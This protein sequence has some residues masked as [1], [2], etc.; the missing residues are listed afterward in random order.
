MQNESHQ[1]NFDFMNQLEIQFV[2]TTIL[3]HNA[4]YMQLYKNIVNLAI[5]LLLSWK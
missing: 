3:L 5:E 4:C 1:T 2:Q